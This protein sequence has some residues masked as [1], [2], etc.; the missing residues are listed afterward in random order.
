MRMD[1]YEDENKKTE[2]KTTRLNKNQDLYADVYLNNVYVDI[3]KL[4]DVMN[5][6]SDNKLEVKKQKEVNLSEYST[7]EEKEYDIVKL[8]E[9]AI[10]NKE[11]VPNQNYDFE[12][13]EEE[14]KNVIESI[15]EKALEEEKAHEDDELMSDLMPTSENTDILPALEPLPDT[16]DVIGHLSAPITDTSILEL[17]D[18]TTTKVSLD[19]LTEINDDDMESDDSFAEEKS[20]KYIKIIVILIVILMIGAGI[21]LLKLL[22]V[23]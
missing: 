3:D 7:Y 2:E 16:T 11:E 20:H 8:V 22:N 21:L 9:E 18:D 1:R 13:K 5:E 17:P 4:N 23:I 14:I 19:M 6:D 12:S 15:N 10:K